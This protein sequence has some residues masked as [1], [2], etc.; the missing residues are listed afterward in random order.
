MRRTMYSVGCEGAS[1]SF[2]ADDPVGL[3]AGRLSRR[4]FSL[5]VEHEP[6][7]LL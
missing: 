6:T 7:D 3:A 2:L 4:N 5:F 1:V